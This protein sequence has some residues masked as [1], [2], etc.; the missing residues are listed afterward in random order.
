MTS[1][2]KA[3][4][5]SILRVVVG[6]A[7]ISLVFVGPQSA[8]GW[9]GLVPL[10]TGLVG[11]CPVYSLLGINTCGISRPDRQNPARPRRQSRERAQIID[12]DSLL[13]VSGYTAP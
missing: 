9:V 8:W 12:C 11:T 2:T 10:I 3:I 6:A 13:L 5:I 1:R 4:W 7:V